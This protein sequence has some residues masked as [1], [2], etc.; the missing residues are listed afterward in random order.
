MSKTTNAS[1]AAGA[2]GG[3]TDTAGGDADT[4]ADI[5]AIKQ[6]KARY[7]RLMDTK[8]WD[9][10]GQVFAEDAVVDFSG[11]MERAG[12][13]G[14]AGIVSGRDNIVSYV[15]DAVAQADTVHHGHMPEIAL[16]GP[17]RAEG[18]WAMQDIVD[19]GAAA[20]FGGLRGYGHYHETYTKDA[21][22]VWRIQTIKLV[23]LRV[24]PL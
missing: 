16:V 19:F 5:E 11:E 10:F 24:D 13:D 8:Q 23:R 3:A 6:V 17:D 12:M 20:P 15:K 22:G 21:G 1:G 7:F 14:T 4:G 9:D 2:G 18:I